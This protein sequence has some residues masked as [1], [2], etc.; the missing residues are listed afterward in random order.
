MRRGA[1]PTSL[2]PGR[3]HPGYHIALKLLQP[4]LDIGVLQPA[5]APQLAPQPGNG[6]DDGPDL[7]IAA[8]VVRAARPSCPAQLA[9]P[10][11][12]PA[13]GPTKLA[14]GLPLGAPRAM[15]MDRS[16]LMRGQARQL[17]IAVAVRAM[18]RSKQ[19]P[20]TVIPS[21]NFE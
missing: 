12:R 13:R 21:S 1:V 4:E 19:K 9:L 2:E 7:R 15:G 17:T 18:G 8:W 20:R 16:A 6:G 3:V 10:G 14:T 11:A 5:A